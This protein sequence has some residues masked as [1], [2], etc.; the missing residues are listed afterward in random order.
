M[1]NGNR[2][3]DNE[4]KVDTVQY[5]THT[6]VLTQSI[7]FWC[8]CLCVKQRCRK[9]PK[10]NKIKYKKKGFFFPQKIYKM[11]NVKDLFSLHS[12]VCKLPTANNINIR[13][14][15]NVYIYIKHKHGE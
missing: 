6:V 7:N 8:M 4:R 15:H 2:Y 1:R 14:T 9:M 11:L 12:L 3:G 5:D 10:T 13:I